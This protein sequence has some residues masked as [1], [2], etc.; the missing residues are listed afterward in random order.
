MKSWRA[1]HDRSLREMLSGVCPARFKV[2]FLQCGARQP[3]HMP[4]LLH[5]VVGGARFLTWVVFESD[6]AHRRSVAVLCM[7]YKIGCNPMHPLHSAL[8]VSYV[9]VRVT[10]GAL[11]AHGYTCTP[12]CRTSQYRTTFILLSVSTYNDLAN[13]VLDGVGLAHHRFPWH[14]CRFPFLFLL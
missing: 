11:V 3:I 13:S 8:P 4:K 5:R 9:L 6:I 1:F 10:L 2:L 14:V 12:R 7:L